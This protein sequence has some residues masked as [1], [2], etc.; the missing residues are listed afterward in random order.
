M[1]E[2][3]FKRVSAIDIVLIIGCVVFYP[4]VNTFFQIILIILGLASALFIIWAGFNED[5][6]M[7]LL[8]T[9]LEKGAPAVFERNYRLIEDLMRTSADLS[10]AREEAKRLRLEIEVHRDQT[11]HNKCWMN[12]WRL[13]Q[14]LKDGKLSALPDPS[15]IP[16]AEMLLGCSTYCPSLEKKVS[17]QDKMMI[18]EIEEVIKKYMHQKPLS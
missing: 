3:R 7:A 13:H 10:E 16:L 8:E 6:I 14:S 11:G 5:P 17:E 12:D 4:Y 15:K 9:D 18:H 2:K 1:S